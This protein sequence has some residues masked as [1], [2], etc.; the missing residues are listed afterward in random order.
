MTTIGILLAIPDPY[1]SQLRDRRLAYGDPQADVVPIHVT[2]L[3]PS[4]VDPKVL[5]EVERH[6]G[7]IAARHAPFRMRLSGTGTFRPISR[8]VFVQLAQGLAECVDLEA[9]IRSGILQRVLQFPFHP[10]VTIVHDLDDRVL[11]TAYQDLADY[12]ADFEMPGFGLYQQGHD[13]T[14]QMLR[15]FPFARDMWAAA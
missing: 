5:P 11:D 3:P 7:A 15:F 10:H 2:L 4:A 13:E 9:R 8:V 1:G 12:S 6:L 14:W